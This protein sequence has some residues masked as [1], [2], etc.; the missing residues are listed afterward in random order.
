M[1]IETEK[2]FAARLSIVSNAIII[3]FKLIAGIISGS[4]SIISEAI[5]SMS[6]FLASVLTYFAVLR[7]SQPPDKEH[8]FGHG[9]YED[10]SGFIEGILIILAS[11]YIVSEAVKKLVVQ[12]SLEFN[13]TLGIIVMG[14]AVVANWL[15]SSYLFSVA[16]RS[17]SIALHADA[18]HLSTD[19]YSSLGVF[20]GLILIK[21]T[22]FTILDPIIA[23][24]VAIIILKTGYTITKDTLNNL[25]DG[26]LPEEE[27]NI[28]RKT[29][30]DCAGI[31]GYKNLKGRKSGSGRDIDLTLLFDENMSIK[32]CHQICD[33]IENEIKN[34]LPHTQITI[35][36]E[37]VLMSIK[38]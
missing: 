31:K 1:K 3:I 22:G 35:H 32:E 37:P 33:N 30:D 16:K 29:L 25:V 2:K 21:I 27:L 19:I 7:S 38:S 10:V 36:C 24:V 17:D 14:I 9:R 28:I 8:P 12:N 23:L 13:S 34:T 15:V 5:H 18:Q 11:V 26:T 4:I 6:D 20:A